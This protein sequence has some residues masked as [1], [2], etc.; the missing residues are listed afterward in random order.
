MSVKGL[1]STFSIILLL[2]ALLAIGI[3]SAQ[4]VLRLDEHRSYVWTETGEKIPYVDFLNTDQFEGDVLEFRIYVS[5]TG[6]PIPDNYVLELRTNMDKLRVW[7]F[8]DDIYY[9]SAS[10]IVWQGKNEHAYPFPSPIILT[11]VVPEPIRQVKEP[12]FE[13][14]NI[15]GIGKDEVYVELTVGTSRDG[16][17]LETIQQKLS[18][19]MKFFSTDEGIKA[20]KREIEKNLEEARGKIGRTDLEED[21][22]GLYEKGHPG[23][24]SKLSAHYK[25]LIM[26]RFE[27]YFAEEEPTEFWVEVSNPAGAYICNDTVDITFGRNLKHGDKVD[28]VKYLQIVLNANPATQ[29]AVDGPGSPCHETNYFGELTEA[30]VIKF[31]TLHEGLTQSGALDEATR[32]E[33]NKLYLPV[34]HVPNG[35]VLNVT[36]THQNGEIQ[37]GS[38]WWAVE[39]VTDGIKGW[40][41]YQK[42]SDETKYLDVGD[43]EELKNRV[44]KLNMK[45]E[46]IPVIL[47]EVSEHRTEFLPDNFPQGIILAMA[48]QESG[49]EGFDNE[50]VALTP[51]GRGIMQ[52]DTDNYV[53]A[54][55]GIRW[56][57]NGAVDYCRGKEGEGHGCTCSAGI[58]YCDACKHYYTNTI[59]G[60][61][62]NIKDGLGALK[63]KYKNSNC[64]YNRGENAEWDEVEGLYREEMGEGVIFYSKNEECE[65]YDSKIE[66]IGINNIEMSCDDFKVIDTVWRYNCREIYSGERCEKSDYLRCVADKLNEIKRT[67]GYEMPNKDTWIERLKAVSRSASVMKKIK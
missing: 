7:K 18:P 53:G 59:Q 35:W 60:I 23:W 66:K 65:I 17:T 37:D 20:A 56:Y 38:V 5:K 21:I 10:V 31:Q 47:Q 19:S 39:D 3:A 61:E 28:A 58:C 24:A 27:N 50:I 15:E 52:I 40:V 13:K 63:D 8:G 42:I 36:N 55:S 49:G 25:E 29:V 2:S 14:Y 45:D 64:C 12:G 41:A 51:W 4:D 48:I 46:R 44:K 6:V 11:G 34:K 9:H 26:E 32:A 33:L 62:A 30:A 22:W 67:F 54:G 43:Q 16:A 1:F 57:N